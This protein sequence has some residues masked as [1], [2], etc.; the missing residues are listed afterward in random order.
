MASPF[1]RSSPGE[2]RELV[3]QRHVARLAGEMPIEQ[4]EI[5]GVTKH[6][7]KVHLAV[8]FRLIEHRGE[9][10]ILGNLVDITDLKRAE[11]ALKENEARFRTLFEKA[12]DC[13]FIKDSLLRY[14]H[15]NPAMVEL[16]GIP[17]S[18]LSGTTEEDLF[19]KQVG[20]RM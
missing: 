20:A 13:I 11:S 17:E 2:H 9:P 1:G 15:V 19:G 10:A 14:T 4:Y 6:G 3:E 8:W 7:D 18:R 5:N 12:R 16:F